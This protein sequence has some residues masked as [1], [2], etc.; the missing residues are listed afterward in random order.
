VNEVVAVRRGSNAAGLGLGVY[1]DTHVV[2]YCLKVASRWRQV[3]VR[4]NGSWYIGAQD[5]EITVPD[6]LI[7]VLKSLA[8]RNAD[9]NRTIARLGRNQCLGG[10]RLLDAR[11]EAQAIINLTSGSKTNGL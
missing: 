9:S 11:I 7:M 2:P 5:G 3:C 6:D 4:N 8:V 10:K 1:K